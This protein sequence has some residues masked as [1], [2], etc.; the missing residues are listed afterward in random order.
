MY[1]ININTSLQSSEVYK[2]LQLAVYIGILLWMYLWAGLSIQSVPWPLTTVCNVQWA[3]CSELCAL[4]S[5]KC[6][7]ST[8]K[9]LWS[10]DQKSK[11]CVIAYYAAS[12]HTGRVIIWEG[13][14]RNLCVLKTNHKLFGFF[15][16][17]KA[18]PIYTLQFIQTMHTSWNIKSWI[19]F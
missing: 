15:T 16:F 14:S 7:A 19:H 12:L 18:K 11:H 10:T 4:C 17:G 13:K 1:L 6:A 9:T 3:L 5:V 8:T 2:F